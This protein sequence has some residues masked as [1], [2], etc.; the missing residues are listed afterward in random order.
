MS[1]SYTAET[2]S[3]ESS[4]ACQRQPMLLLLLGLILVASSGCRTTSDNQIDLLERELRVQ[5]DYIYELEDYV[6]EYS[7]KLRNCRSCPPPQ[8]AAYSQEIHS[9]DINEPELEAAPKHTN[10]STRRQQVEEKSVLEPAEEP[11]VDPESET[12][13][14]DLP[15]TLEGE[16]IPE[17]SPEDIE[18]PG[19]LDFDLEEPVSDLDDA[20][21]LQQVAAMELDDES[22]DDGVLFIPDPVDFNAAAEHDEEE[23]VEEDSL[24]ELAEQPLVED[25]FADE[26]VEET[27]A[28][29]EQMGEQMAE[30]IDGRVAERLEV[31]Q[32]FR[33]EGDDLSPQNLLTVIEAL[34]ANGEPVDLDGEV[35]LMVMLPDDEGIEGVADAPL[36]RLKRWDFTAEETIAAWQST[37]LGDGLH[38]ELPLEKLRLPQSPLELWVR[39]VTADGRKLLAQLPFEASQL[40]DVTEG[41]PQ[42]LPSGLAQVVTETD[43]KTSVATINTLRIETERIPAINPKSGK[44]ELAADQPSSNQPRWRASMQ[45]TDRTAEGFAT[46][47]SKSNGW[48]TQAPGRQPY[49]P[50]RVASAQIPSRPSPMVQTKTPTKPV[51]SSGR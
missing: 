27:A 46:T 4:T 22:S 7:E 10:K 17:I 29:V 30:Q 24:E 11:E 6:V 49:A 9:Q 33:G 34:D 45:R 23:Y 40:T 18:I 16:Q 19:I 32:L 38:L 5:E 8:T 2:L 13:T 37:D 28:L 1:K 47:S 26:Q 25:L 12:N 20:H 35:S 15:E 48:T 43:S 41:A 21:S 14:D 31:A 44:L 42:P 51:W 39:L 50:A 36:M 3:A